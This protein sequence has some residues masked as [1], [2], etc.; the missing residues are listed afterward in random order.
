MYTARIEHGSDS[1]GNIGHSGVSLSRSLGTISD[2][3]KA[4][5]MLRAKIEEQGGRLP[6][7]RRK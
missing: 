6:P 1:M 5:Q 3:V 2:K 4:L 7:G